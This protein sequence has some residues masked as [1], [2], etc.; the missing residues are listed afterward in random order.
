MVFGRA[1]DFLQ[2][3][4]HGD[5][6]HLC[7]LC[8][9]ERIEVVRIDCTGFD[10]RYIAEGAFHGFAGGLSFVVDAD[11]IQPDP[12]GGDGDFHCAVRRHFDFCAVLTVDLES[13]HDLFIFTGQGRDLENDLFVRIG[14]NPFRFIGGDGERSG[15]EQ[16]GGAGQEECQ[17]FF[18][19]LRFLCFF[20]LAADRFRHGKGFEEDQQPDH[21]GDRDGEDDEPVLDHARKDEPEEG[22]SGDR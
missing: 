6:I 12:A 17:E 9:P 22:N 14:V 5:F 21:H 19:L 10:L 18:H 13:A 11:G 8:R 1:G 15:G 2:N 3:R 16:G 7:D 20:F 4:V